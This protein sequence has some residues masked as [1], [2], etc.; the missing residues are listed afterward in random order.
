MSE[1]LP[2]QIQL[3]ALPPNVSWTPQQLGDALVQRMRLVSAQSF[4]LF[5]SGST[6]PSSNVGPWLR[7]GTEWYVWSDTAGAYVPISVPVQSLGYIIG[8][9]APDPTD[10]NFWIETTVLGAPLALKI[11]YSGAWTDVY[12]TTLGA[13]LT[14]A[15]AAAAYAP[16]ASPTFTGTPAA[17]T[18]APGTNTTQIANTA[19]VTAAVAAIPPGTF[20]VYPARAESTGGPQSIPIDNAPHRIDLGSAPVNPAPAPF[21][22]GSSRYVAPA[23]GIYKV[24]FTASIGNDGGVSASMNI[25]IEVYVNG[26]PIGLVSFNRTPSPTGDVWFLAGPIPVIQLALNDYVELFLTANDGTNAANL[27]VLGVAVSFFRVSA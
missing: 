23:A 24:D 25:E 22:T 20:S 17:P 15:A 7:N 10:T 27:D 8:N 18:A 9:T 1:Q 12:A 19:F 4:S 26:A 6:E 13:Y 11:Y 14:I 3:G 16:L 21:N 2:I 5:V